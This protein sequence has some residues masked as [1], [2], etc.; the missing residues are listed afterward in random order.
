MGLLSIA[1]FLM[2]RA[3]MNTSLMSGC[4]LQY[5]K[6]PTTV[7]ESREAFAKITEF[8]KLDDERF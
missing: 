1:D 7:K 5:E 4:A 8:F 2:T 3:C 6:P